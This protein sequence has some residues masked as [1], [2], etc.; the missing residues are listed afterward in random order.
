MGKH[1][2]R[3]LP[4]KIDVKVGKKVHQISH[5]HPVVEVLLV[6][7]VGD[8]TLGLDTGAPAVDEDL[9]RG[10]AEKA[11]RQFDQRCLAAAVRPEQTDNASGKDLQI[12]VIQGQCTAIGFGQCTAP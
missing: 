6:R 12:N 2:H 9:S 3:P 11:V 5:T 10:R 1:F 7:Q 8:Q 4:V